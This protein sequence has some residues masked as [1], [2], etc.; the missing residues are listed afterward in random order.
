MQT[1]LLIISL[2]LGILLA[3]AVVLLFGRARRRGGESEVGF[4]LI[5]EQVNEL[6]RTIDRK[7]G[8]STKT[9]HDSV[10]SQLS[11]SAK[12]IRN[13]TVGL[14][15]LDETNRQVISFAD[16]L[17]SL[18]DILK[19]PKHRG[20]LGEYYLETLLHNVLPQIGRASCRERV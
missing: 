13:V 6:A 3:L 8:E 1:I 15:K 9:L 10:R 14:T 16:Q 17:Q 2:V 5:L 12:L 4:R 19:N 11:E 20:I 18:Q 7:I